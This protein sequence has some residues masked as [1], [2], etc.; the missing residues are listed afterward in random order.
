M[1]VGAKGTRGG[2]PVVP[3]RQSAV[4]PAGAAVDTYVDAVFALVESVRAEVS[5]LTHHADRRPRAADLEPLEPW[6]RAAMT[7]AKHPRL[8]GLGFIAA[9]DAFEDQAWCLKW[10]QQAEDGILS[11]LTPDLD[12]QSLGFYDFTAARWFRDP[13]VTGERSVVGPYVDF[14]GTDEYVITLTVPM[15]SD[16][17]ILGV[18]GADLRLGDLADAVM[19]ALCSTGG[20]AALVNASGR[21]VVSNSPRWHVGALLRERHVTVRQECAQAPWTVVA[22]DEA[23]HEA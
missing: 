4:Q 20:D 14:A 18:A 21:V 11:V 3:L 10:V 7:K 19:P 6:L 2:A 12:P 16:G 5:V 13:I 9:M 22:S 17:H 23:L 8:A 15:E 1:T